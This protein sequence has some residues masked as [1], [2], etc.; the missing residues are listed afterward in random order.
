MSPVVLSK[1]EPGEDLDVYL[2]VS[3]RAV[4]AVL[5]RTDEQNV[6]RPVY[7]VSHA[8]NGPE[9]RYSR[10][11]KVVYALYIAAKKLT[12]YFQGRT[13][14]VLTDQPIGSVLRNS[15]SSGRLVKWA[16]MLTQF[17]MEYKPRPAIK[18]QALAD[19]VVEC[20]AREIET[21][22]QPGPD[23]QWWELATDGSSSKRGAGGGVVIISPEGFKLYHAL[24]FSFSPTNNE[25]EYEAFIAGL[26]YV[27]RLGAQY[28]RARTDSALVVG[29]VLGN[30]EANGERL[31]QY[32]NRVLA[33]LADFQGHAVEHVPR[34]EN[35]DADVL[36]KLVQEAPE[37]ISKIARIEELTQPVI[38]T[39]E[40][41]PVEPT[42]KS[43]IEDLMQY[44]T[45]GRVPD[46]EER[47]HKVKL[48]AP[49]FQVMEGKLYRRSH[50]G[51]LM[52]CLNDFEADLV[53][54][55]LHSGICSSH[56][57]GKALARRIMLIGYYWPS[58]Q[59]DCK[60]VVREC[61]ACQLF[62]KVPG[63]PATFYQP[64]STAIP[65]ARWGVDIV[66]P[67]TRVAGR[68]RFIIVAID[69]FSKW[70]EAEPLATI[71]SQ[72]C[73]RF[74]W[75]NVVSRFGVPV[76]LVTDNG[77]QFEG[78]YF[79]NFLATIGT[80]AIK[81]SVAYPQGNGQVE[82]ANRTILDGLK[83]KLYSAGRNWADELPYILWAYRTTPRE[84]TKE[85]PFALVYG[86]EARLPIEAW[87]PTAREKEFDPD[88]NDEMM[89]VEL[90][91]VEEKREQVA[92]RVIEYQKKA[93]AYHDARVRTRYFQVG[94]FVLRKREAS[95]PLEGGE[96]SQSWEGP[97]VIA[98]VIR[99]G[100]YKLQTTTGKA[101]DRVWNSE[102]LTLF[103]H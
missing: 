60:R 48:R 78:A 7:Y 55:E 26:Q 83:K 72:Q 17:A 51:P 54:T 65:F 103:H 33:L 71:T 4:S 67:F 79:A 75:R 64:V 21:T 62:A 90:D 59:L 77:K 45:D 76:Q 22:P 19:F 29:Q 2:G 35:V 61:K 16:L 85:T 6:Q 9:T 56:Q 63:R 8:L 98:A 102:N 96:L 53:M 15:N 13:V 23:E 89:A 37:H 24:I 88:A 40:V 81:S 84:A 46:D 66:G 25:A 41:A 101:V 1:P 87:V 97:Y 39:L 36:S 38:D 94:D 11:E 32:R 91:S 12:P 28:V 34:A 44:L 92:K 70:V 20:T 42:E 100:T 86:A 57:G 14:H 10:L 52:R 74:L 58:I 50:G 5:C 99:P 18:G 95:R 80:K 73:A 93:K 3:D 47:A 27:R 30:F 82:N 49:R 69:Y 68:K 31:I 43:W